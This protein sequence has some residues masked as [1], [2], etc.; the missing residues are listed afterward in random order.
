MSGRPTESF[1]RLLRDSLFGIDAGK[2]DLTDGEWLELYRTSRSQ[3]CQAVIF[4]SASRYDM[5][6]KIREAWSKEVASIE[7]RNA[8]IRKVTEVQSAAWEK[9][10]ITAVE[11]KGQAVAALYPRP[12]HRVCGDIDWWFP[13]EE[14]WEKA[15]AAAHE[16]KCETTI[17]SDGDVH[18]ALAGVVVEYHKKGFRENTPEGR[19]AFLC[20][21]IAKHAMVFGVG[22]RQVC[23]YALTIRKYD[24]TYDRA[25]VASFC[26][27][28]KLNRF[29]PILNRAVEILFAAGITDQKD[30][31]ID[32]MAKDFIDL[33]MVDGNFGHD[34]KHMFIGFFMRLRFF[35]RC[36]PGAFFGRWSALIT[37]R[38]KRWFITK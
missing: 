22:M 33:V 18:Y 37:G 1:F 4:D 14:D 26:K 20:R 8:R 9:R 19:I 11:L 5:P 24:S 12:E 21:H 25:K 38:I 34:K 16:N 28:M 35:L 6:V 27:D 10:G 36:A 2:I 31:S 23:D 30:V 15:I 17:D 7:R 13:I 29:L 3:A 32:D